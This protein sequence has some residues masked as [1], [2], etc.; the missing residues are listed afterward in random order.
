[1]GRRLE[2][3]A[4]PDHRA[5]LDA[6]IK[7]DIRQHML[8][9]GEDPDAEPPFERP[10]LPRDL[11]CKLGLTQTGFATLLGIPVATYAT[12]SRTA[13]SWSPPRG[14]CSSWLTASRAALRALQGPR[15]A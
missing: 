1:V 15:A 10:V 4:R 12:G 13:S 8:E 6:T 11:R 7:T 3:P 14:L 5:R 2:P 9:D